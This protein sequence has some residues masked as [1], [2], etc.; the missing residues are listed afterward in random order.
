MS[1]TTNHR[2]PGIHC[3]STRP[4]IGSKILVT[5]CTASIIPN[6]KGAGLKKII[7]RSN[8]GLHH[9]PVLWGTK[10]K[11]CN[12]EIILIILSWT[13]TEGCFGTTWEFF[14]V[15][16]DSEGV[17]VF[18]SCDEGG[19][20]NV[21]RSVMDKKYFT[22]VPVVQVPTMRDTIQKKRIERNLSVIL[23]SVLELKIRFHSF[24]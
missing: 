10:T 13:D 3:L 11:D 12:F 18:E 14:I 1:T 24:W 8:S 17:G 6:L 4:F 23:T 9:H 20:L 7:M 16:Q 5:K 15:F 21:P 19:I 2:F 22:S